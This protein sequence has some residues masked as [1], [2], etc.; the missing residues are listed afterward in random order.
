MTLIL[1]TPAC[2]QSV[3]GIEKP[4]IKSA[5]VEVV[6]PQSVPMTL[7]EIRA[8]KQSIEAQIAE[9]RA[10]GKLERADKIALLKLNDKRFALMHNHQEIL[11]KKIRDQK[12]VLAQQFSEIREQIKN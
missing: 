7:E 11:D 6:A 5:T 1:T 4:N 3:E 9:I 12:E 8:E 10:K 2:G